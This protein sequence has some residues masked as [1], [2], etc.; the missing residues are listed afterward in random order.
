MGLRLS[1]VGFK[2]YCLEFRVQDFKALAGS[3]YHG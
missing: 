2:V 1:G 3:V